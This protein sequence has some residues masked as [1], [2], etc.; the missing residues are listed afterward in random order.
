MGFADKIRAV[1]K[2]AQAELDG[3]TWPPS[4]EQRKADNREHDEAERRNTNGS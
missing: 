3:V 2:Q 1:A 4:R